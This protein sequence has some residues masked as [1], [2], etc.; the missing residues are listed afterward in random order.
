MKL[1]FKLTLS[2]LSL[3]LILVITYLALPTLVTELARYQLK[4]QG[5]T[6][7]GIQ[8]GTISLTMADI[9]QLQLSNDDY[10]IKLSGVQVEYELVALLS[11]RM[12]RIHI[13][14]LSIYSIRDEASTKTSKLPS[15]EVL[16]G[17]LSLTWYDFLPANA[18]SIDQLSIYSETG[19]QSLGASLEFSK[20][21]RQIH[22][23]ISLVDS[24]QNPFQAK[25]E[26]SPDTGVDIQIYSQKMQ[27]L[28]ISLK[29]M[30][31]AN[32][33]SGT[34][35]ID[36]EQIA[37]MLDRSESLSGSLQADVS[38]F[39]KSGS[40]EIYFTIAAKGSQLALSDIR[41][42]TMQS[43]LE[44]R[45]TQPD[46][47]YQ[48]TFMPASQF[49]FLDIQQG[50][51]T[52]QRLQTGLPQSLVFADD[53]IR[54][55]FDP[56]TRIVL[57]DLDMAPFSSPQV[58]LDKL[59]LNV[60]TADDSLPTCQFKMRLT[61]PL[62]KIDNQ[63]IEPAPVQIEG[64]C[65][66]R[67]TQIWS[68]KADSDRIEYENPDYVL[69]LD[70]CQLSIGNAEQGKRLDPDPAELGGSFLCDTS[71][72][73]DAINAQFRFNPQRNTG[74]ADFGISDIAP[75]EETPLFS[76]V[77]KEW[78]QP[79]EIVSGTMSVQGQYRWW[80]N[81]RGLE[82]DHLIVDL[83]VIAAGGHYEGILFSG[84]NYRDSIEI[85]PTLKSSEFSTLSVEHIDIAV[86]VTG[87]SAR[88]RFSPSSIGD[89]PVLEI[90]RLN[91]AL[92]DGTIFTNIFEVDLNTD[93]QSL[94]LNVE[95]LDLAQ[96]VA[97][98]QL[99]GL[100]ATGLLDGTV[101]VTV[102]PRGIRITDGKINARKPGGQIQ[103]IP[104]SETAQTGNSVPGS[105]L[106][107]NIL[108]NLYYDSLLVD[109]DYEEDG[110]LT[111]ELAIQ[112]ISPQVDANRPIHFNLTLEQ[113]LLTLLKGLRYAQGIS[114][115][116]DHNVQKYFK[117]NRNALN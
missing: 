54:M 45:I 83:D 65:P 81:S 32:G 18:L 8:I 24:R 68:I 47:V 36:L 91:L 1:L 51:N 61:S 72:L 55:V 21:G 48:F 29:P 117:E 79:F 108:E 64:H 89:L 33:L 114:D 74:R 53:H 78:S 102:S 28:S 90:D 93:R 37:A 27:P 9:E 75:D 98:Q 2:I 107:L 60:F 95:G 4:Q 63:Y 82:R 13:E 26:I 86:P 3:T 73:S 115:D 35:R 49:E 71:Q 92:L 5:F 7:V 50:Q 113:N 40:P 100:A 77:L 70:H 39:S 22:G 11:G 38:Y 46:K 112:G 19:V 103:Y 15:P 104:S 116:I 23:E 105:E 20:L 97:M 111:M 17:F 57:D 96:I 44:G 84:L 109:V 31:G 6:E 67:E 34:L 43:R 87:A 14:A 69:T 30:Q 101:P 66:E 41:I 85:L 76:S 56:K 25:L 52:L 16:S 106:V 99:E 12:N 10:R 88:I 62:I 59:D 42:K 110:Q 80:Q 94:L 58:G